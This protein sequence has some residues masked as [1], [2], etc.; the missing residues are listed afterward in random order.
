ME[1][2]LQSTAEQGKVGRLYI[3]RCHPGEQGSKHAARRTT[4]CLP[5]E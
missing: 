5:W 2:M 1:K 3:P 4:L